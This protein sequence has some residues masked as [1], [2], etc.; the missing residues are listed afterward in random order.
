MR[1][2][3]VERGSWLREIPAAHA[4]AHDALGRAVSA[5]IARFDPPVPNSGS[6]AP[7]SQ[8]ISARSSMRLLDQKRQNTSTNPSSI[9]SV[10]E[11]RRG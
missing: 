2:R 1:S 6:M 8:W 7:R 11:L 5:A 3:A 4:E 10:E 9:A